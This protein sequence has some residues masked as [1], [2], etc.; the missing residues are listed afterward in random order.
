MKDELE[1]PVDRD[2]V[3]LDDRSHASRSDALRPLERCALMRHED[4]TAYPRRGGIFL[5][6]GIFGV[7]ALD[8]AGV[9]AGYDNRNELVRRA[10]DGM[11]PP[12][13]GNNYQ[14][15]RSGISSTACSLRR[16]LA[17][18]A[19]DRIARPSST[20]GNTTMFTADQP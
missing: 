10:R 6:A 19:N 18:D 11:G 5:H 16:R 9:I 13:L 4:V 7:I 12:K 1:H 2:A 15:L 20:G 8:G 17:N 14:M 3:A